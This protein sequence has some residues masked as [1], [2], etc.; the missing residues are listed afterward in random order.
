MGMRTPGQLSTHEEREPT[1]TPAIPGKRI[2]ETP[3][4]NIR[5]N[6]SALAGTRPL[7]QRGVSY[8]LHKMNTKFFQKNPNKREDEE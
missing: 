6:L 8:D 3:L 7:G 5:T 2:N 1:L 4:K